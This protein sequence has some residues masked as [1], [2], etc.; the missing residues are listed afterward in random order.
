MSTSFSRWDLPQTMLDAIA[1]AGWNDPTEI[2]RDAIPAALSGNDVIA[3]ARTGSGKTGAFAIPIINQVEANGKPQA[4]VLCPTRELATQVAAEFQWLKGESGISIL[5]VYGGTDLEKQAKKLDDGQEII[6]GTPG[7]V[8]DMAKR[9]HLDLSAMTV[10][11]LDEADRMLDM[12]FWPDIAWVVE[13]MTSRK[14]T[15]LFSATFPQEIIDAAMEFTTEPDHVMSDDLEVEIPEIDQAWIKVG[16]ANKLWALGRIL[17]QMSSEDQILV[18]CNTKRMVDMLVERLGKHRFQ[19]ASL[20]GD[21]SQNVREKVMRRFREKEI[22]VL[23]ATDVA[24]RGL[25][26]ESV[27]IVVNYDLPI[28]VESYVHRIGRTG[29]MGRKGAAWSFASGADLV[30]LE[31]IQ[32]TWNMVIEEREAPSLPEGV[33][34]DPVRQQVDWAELSDP[35][36]MIEL[37][38]DGGANRF[39]SSRRLADWIVEETK[40]PEIAIGE[41]R[42]GE[43]QSTVQIHSQRAKTVLEIVRRREFEGEQVEVLTSL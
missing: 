18:F 17:T 25:D 2:Q 34:R 5:P 27:T 36:G 28:D 37:K 26:V 4:I 8:I 35:F 14:Q 38:L 24:A 31:Q 1:E 12:G 21:M 16:R 11:C 42:L 23:I 19:S 40:I 3:Q 22:D 29:R 13:N 6:V 15:L 10:L 43:K 41:I 9:G 20:H 30:K 32:A 33:D 7:R 39:G